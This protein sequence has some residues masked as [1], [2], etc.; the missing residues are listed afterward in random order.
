LVSFNNNKL[1]KTIP[2]VKPITCKEL[3][4]CGTFNYFIDNPSK[5]ISWK[6]IKNIAKNSKIANKTACLNYVK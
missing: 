5:A 4:I 1:P 2:I 6:V 3:A